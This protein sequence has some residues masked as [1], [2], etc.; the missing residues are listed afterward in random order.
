MKFSS[1]SGFVG[2]WWISIRPFSL[3]AST[4]PVIFGSVLAFVFGNGDFSLLKFLMA[5]F[6]MVFLHS[7]AN[8]LND[9]FD[10]KNGLDKMPTP[11]SGGVVR[12]IISMKQAWR[13]VYLFFVMGTVLGLLLSWMVSPILL[14]IGFPGL[15]IGIFYTKGGKYS[16]K[17][18]ALGDLAVFLNFGVLGSLG[19]WFVQTGSLSW[20]PVLWAVPIATLVIAILHANNWRDIASDQQGHV[21]T[22]ASLLG[23][24]NSLRYYGFLIFAPFFMV[25][26]LVLIPYFLFPGY[27]FM[28]FSFAIVLLSL[29]MALKLWQKALNR[30]QPKNPIDFIALDGATGQYNLVFGLL[31]TGALILESVI[32][33][34]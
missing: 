31:S 26:A 34:L 3:P 24:K 30:K 19:A 6:G 13:A 9:I 25:L 22:I 29:P 20:I 16:L 32:R 11:V 21:Y 15:L 2:K 4:M 17:Y 18:R 1:V 33:L 28:P 23:D 14:L 12:G 10:F 8:I 27:P 7:G 5:F